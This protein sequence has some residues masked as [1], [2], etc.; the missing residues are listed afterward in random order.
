MNVVG[1]TGKAGSGKTMISKVLSNK[2]FVL[3]ELD[4]IGH[5]VLNEIPVELLIDNFGRSI[6]NEYGNVDRKKLGDI[7]FSNYDK[8]QLLN[9]IVHPKIHDRVKKRITLN[10][11]SDHLIDGALLFDIGLSELCDCI[12]WIDCSEDLAIRRMVKR[13]VSEEKA[14]YILKSQKHLDNFKNESDKV[15]LNDSSA[16]E[17]IDSI[18]SFLKKKGIML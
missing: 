11:E 16:D 8:L 7:V 2:G 4:K 3:H 18:I 10:N 12:I 5:Q 6:I 1:L 15:F 17:L 14:K 9:S 13:G